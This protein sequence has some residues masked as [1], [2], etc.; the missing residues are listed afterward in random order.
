MGYFRELRA[1]GETSCDI[2]ASGY[3]ARGAGVKLAAVTQDDSI[4]ERL[5]ELLGYVE[6][7]IKLDERP[8][9]RLNEY[10]LPTGQTFVFHQ[11][12]FHA[13]PGI[14]HD[15]TD[16]DGPKWLTMQRIKRGEPPEPSDDIAPWLNLPPDPDKEPT[17]REFVIWTVSESE[18][19]DLLA[20]SQVRPEDCA[21]AIGPQTKGQF[22]VTLRLED[23]PEIT[24]AA[25]QYISTKWL[26]WAEAERPKRKS[27]ALYQRLFEVAQLAELA[28]AEQ[29]IELVWGIGLTRWIKDGYEVDLP[30]LERLVEI[31]IDQRAG[32]EIRIRPRSALATANLRPYEEM[33]IEG[34]PLALD[35]A[36]RA[37]AAVD[38]EDGVSPYRV[39][40]FEP[41]LRACQ[42]RLDAEGRYLPDHEKLNA[43]A[44]VPAATF[45]LSVSDRWV[46]FVRRRSDNFLLN[47]ISNLK[48]SIESATDIPEPA[49]T[50]V[51]GPSQEKRS[52]QPLG[53]AIGEKIEL[54]DVSIPASPLGDLFFPKPFNNDQIEI[55]QRLERSDGI[56]VQGPPGT[57]KTHTIS[58][59]ICHYMATGRRV[60]VVSHGE[61]ALAV[62]RQQ[63]PEEVRDLAI[64]ITTSEREGFKQL[65]TAVRL[66]QSIVEA[67]RPS[68]QARLIE[69]IEQS[70]LQMR[71][72]L[73][74]VDAEIEQIATAQLS[75]VPGTV[76]TPAE[77]ARYVSESRE[78]FGWF[79]DR[80][81]K[82][83]H[84]L[85]FTDDDM[86][87]LRSARIEIGN[88]IEHIDAVLPSIND[89]PDGVELAR[90]H[91][92]LVRSEDFAKK[93][94]E[95]ESFSARIT[96]NESLSYADSAVRACEILISA[97]KLIEQR[98][99][100]REIADRALDQHPVV[101]ALNSLMKEGSDL[102][103]EQATYLRYPVSLPDRLPAEAVGI[104]ARLA[105]GEQVFGLFAFKNRAQRPAIEAIQVVGRSPKDAAEWRLV[106]D[107]IQWRDKYFVV[108]RTWETI[109]T[110]CGAP[111]INLTEIGALQL[112]PR[113]TIRLSS[114]V[115]LLRGVVTALPDAMRQLDSTLTQITDCDDSARSLWS[116]P[117]RLALIRDVLRNAVAATRLAASRAEIKRI[118][119]C[120]SADG[121]KIGTLARNF[122]VNVVGRPSLEAAKIE[123]AWE[124]L[125]AS[126]DDLAQLRT[127]F[128]KV[129]GMSERIEAAGSPEWARRVLC[130]P[131]NNANDHIIPADWKEVWDWAAAQSYLLRI[132]QRDHLQ[133]LSDERIQID[134]NVAKT[135]ERLV[136]E[137]T[138]YAL[139]G[140]MTGPVRSALM[141]FA[142][143][144]RKIGKGTGKGAVR[145]RK[146]ARTAMSQ[147]YGAIPCWIMP[148]WR[149]AEQLPAEL[150]SFDLVI[151]DEA[152]QSD[153][154]EVTAL[155]RGKKI[156]V[157]G[158]DKQVSP[159]AAFIEDAKIERLAR[160]FLKNQP[161]KTLLLPGA[162][163][164]D[165]AKVMFPDKFVMLREH[166]RCVEPIIRFSMQF[167]PEPLI[168][169]RIPT[170]QERIAPPLLDIFV[171]DGHRIGDKVNLREAQV[172]VEEIKA[173]V[174][175]PRIARIE[176]LD[177]W[178]SVGVISLIGAKQAALI[179]R[180]L[181]DE[182]GD[183]IMMRHR[184]ACGDSATFQ[185]NE[186]DI[187]FLSMIADPDSKQ[188]QTAAHFEQRFNVALSRA[189][190]RMVLVRSVNEEQLNPS[191]LKAK[192]IRHFHD[193]MVGAKPPAGDLMVMCESN[194]ERDVLSRLL[195]RGY[196][197]KP[198]VGALGYRIDL[199]VEGAGD[200]RLAV[201][202]DGDKYHGPER[203]ADDMQRQRVLERVGW[204]FWRC[205]ASSFTLDA[206]A[207]MAD[208]FSTLERLQIHPLGEN[209]GA[210]I[211]V[212][213]KT[214]HTAGTGSDEATVLKP[215]TIT[216]ATKTNGSGIRSGDRVIIRY[217]DDN[218]I[219]TFTLSSD[220]N[221][222]A[223]GL[224]W[225]NSPL[226]R[227]LIGL[228]EEDETEFEVDGGKRRVLV[229]RTERQPT[230]H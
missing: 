69:D 162:S 206:D 103:A 150:G 63:L 117:Q 160:G 166:F 18:K 28:G 21:S 60:L 123:S 138:F 167:Y 86:A 71:E 221:D 70:I 204:R 125:R 183:E 156:L 24:L 23:R 151:I 8:A 191:D 45:H 98:K 203:W 140:S 10:R 37:I 169:L 115:A 105:E 212:E 207:C 199:V 222:P 201:E 64:S 75:Q 170:A 187:V 216:S 38:V 148:S 110:E 91:D 56:V 129:R 35:A 198:Q 127:E 85:D 87:A 145:H 39:D 142:T 224:L 159:T 178:R 83:T 11:H 209:D 180:M 107:Y 137:R 200:R 79:T 132:D 102:I 121:G 220:R 54:G 7:V 186:R 81:T 184:I 155:L 25:Q 196:R 168:P 223:N 230:M 228:V 12:D 197:V 120:F 34:A 227:Q 147:C 72:R 82:F 55:V 226:G 116:N 43:S 157:V 193:P 92:N 76:S 126:I 17:L 163:L 219:A 179:N 22:D 94:A 104:V 161:F 181:L 172:I 80:P 136:R 1:R 29:P 27:I 149:V 144:L 108:H 214:A 40:T 141:M 99:W 95:H 3:F 165:L 51:T 139:G 31:E 114:L 213:H 33:K 119:D 113:S 20:R 176:A 153:I 152:S 210:P 135:F 202:C 50:L 53:T 185:G 192:V 106:H 174:A 134:Q 122:L 62:L 88:R 46:I 44:P 182:L 4:V 84:S 154:K 74:A 2:L 58:N 164:Y 59:I 57:G 218:K 68:E 78:R 175:D 67:L 118:A 89:L 6:Q 48:S 32:G 15:L 177:R 111:Q 109:A 90:L 66:L 217:L 131:I 97:Q 52:W 146:D 16:E 173:L 42:T 14:T 133:R 189:R 188:A 171:P 19:D 194:F 93:A 143:A 26:S 195:L 124:K 77:L 128:Q 130:E 47:D 215:A 211:Y 5:T 9:F 61:P 229:V 49:K 73:A 65:E 208:L 96:S 101:I 205:W 41:S 158:D 190:D 30:L 100:L 225:I 112:D 36:R 13:L